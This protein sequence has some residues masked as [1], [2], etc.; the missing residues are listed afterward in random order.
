MQRWVQVVDSFSDLCGRAI[1]WLTVGMVIV[2]LVV[3]VLRYLFDLGWIWLQE[4]V[5]WMHAAVL[6]LGAA[7]T[8]R[9]EEHVRV[10]VFYRR[11]SPQGKAWV[12]ILGAVFFLLPMCGFLLWTSLDY[13]SA[14]WALRETSREAGGLPYPF[15]PLM[16]T[17]IP[18]A[19]LLLLLQGLAD[20][21]RNVAVVR[22]R[23][24][25]RVPTDI[26]SGPV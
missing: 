26:G 18:A 16:K 12:D 1:A 9:H 24:P 15:V 6:M 11:R 17:L 21:V 5:T 10:D 13:V 8:L 20:L 14:S 4:T 22:G 2:T 3:V 19:A 25:P 23:Q 7:Y